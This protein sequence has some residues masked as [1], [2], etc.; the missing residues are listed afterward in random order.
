[1]SADPGARRARRPSPELV[2]V[3]MPVRNAEDEVGRQLAALAEQDHG[4]PWELLVV[5]NGCEDG[6]LDVVAAWARRLPLEV[7]DARSRAGINVA[8][9]RGV[10]RARGDLLLFCDADDRA[11][12]GWI[13][14]MARAAREWDIV[15]GR[16][17]EVSLNVGRRP[18]PRPSLPSDRLP[19]GL[20]FL[21]F[22]PGANL[23][24][25]RSVLAALG[26]FDERFELGNDDVEL[27]FRA[28]LRGFCVGF[29]PDAVM[30]YR[31][32]TDPRGLFRQFRNYGRGE[33]I[34]YADFRTAGM[35][36][37]PF[38][39]VARRY[40]KLLLNLPGAVLSPRA[41]AHWAIVAGFS[42]GRVEGSL[43]CRVP[44]L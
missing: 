18:S 3:I 14:A 2:S 30:A 36:R 6:T 43:R 16:L 8:R 10:E 39:E 15:G 42:A 21:P 7:V 35:C 27:A 38:A 44:Y 31:H 40:A 12:P 34:L 20:G 37:P 24:V 29:A 28:Q 32:R 26:G 19:L 13:G 23:G 11:E 9:N 22:A 1:M 5:D 4:G 25:W 17:D 33:P 41:R